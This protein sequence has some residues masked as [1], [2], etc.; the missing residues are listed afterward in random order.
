MFAQCRSLIGVNSAE[1]KLEINKTIMT[2]NNNKFVPQ[3]QTYEVKYIEVKE[4]S[5]ISQIY[6]GFLGCRCPAGS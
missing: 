3:A 6:L 5:K 4:P 2:D 1:G